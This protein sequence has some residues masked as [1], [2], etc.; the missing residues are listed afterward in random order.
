MTTFSE[1]SKGGRKT[2]V[3]DGFVKIANTIHNMQHTAIVILGELQQALL[4][5]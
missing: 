2:S 5:R 3:L 1:E 4:I